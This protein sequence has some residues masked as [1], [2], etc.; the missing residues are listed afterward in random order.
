MEQWLFR[1]GVYAPAALPW[2]STPV[3]DDF[4]REL[5][6]NG[7]RRTPLLTLGHD[8]YQAYLLVEVHDRLTSAAPDR[9]AYLVLAWLGGTGEWIFC[10]G[11]PDLLDLLT[12]LAPIVQAALQTQRT[13]EHDAEVLR[14]P[15]QHAPAERRAR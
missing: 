11:L 12:R 1:N 3:R 9:P 15:R 6:A 4:E 7:Y 13:A 8:P 5:E 14:R 10:P 2:T